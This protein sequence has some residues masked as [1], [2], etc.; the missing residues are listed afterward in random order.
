MT[1]AKLQRHRNDLPKKRSSYERRRFFPAGKLRAMRRRSPWSIL[2]ETLGLDLPAN[3]EA[4]C[5]A[6]VAVTSI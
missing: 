4:G 3:D 2:T 1:G 5:E 6:F